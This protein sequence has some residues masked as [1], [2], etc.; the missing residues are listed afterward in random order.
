ML[1]VRLSVG[2]SGGDMAVW[3]LLRLDLMMFSVSR[4]YASGCRRGSH[5]ILAVGVRG[6]GS[7]KSSHVLLGWGLVGRIRTLRGRRPR[8]ERFRAVETLLALVRLHVRD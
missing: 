7:S 1:V 8:I 5:L 2:R 3:I 4:V 6:H